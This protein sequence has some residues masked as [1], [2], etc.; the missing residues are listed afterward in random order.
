[1]AKFITQTGADSVP[2]TSGWARRAVLLAGLA[3]GATGGAAEL[4]TSVA[5][6]RPDQL[7]LLSAFNSACP[8][9]TGNLALRCRQLQ[10]LTAAQQKQAIVSLTPFQFLPQTGLPVKLWPKQ[11]LSRKRQ[12]ATDGATAQFVPGAVGGGSGDFSLRDGPWGLIAQAKFQTGQKSLPV[13]GF[14]SDSYELT[15]GADYSFSEQLTAGAAFAY[16]YGDTQ[17]DHDAGG[18]HSDIYR[19]MLFGNYF[20]PDGYYLNGLG[21]YTRYDNNLQR[22]FGYA[23]FSGNTA[24]TPGTDIYSAVFSFGKEFDYQEW[25]FN[26]YLRLEYL[27]LQVDGYLEQG[28][29]GL[30]YAV[31]GQ[32]DDSFILIPGLQISR[33]FS[34]PWGVLTPSLRFEYEHQ[35]LNDNRRIDM[36]LADAS[37]GSGRFFLN[38]GN[39]D[40]D[41]CDLGGSLA[42]TFA[43]GAAAFLRYEARLG[44]SNLGSQIV[45]LGMRL[46][47]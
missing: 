23:G 28:G 16:S 29:Q 35:F 24:S 17:M 45:E 41:Y 39:P 20:L 18:M 11:I 3:S 40:R 14:V 15:L 47:F 6:L 2:Q 32:A 8:G 9:A 1:M 38:T 19:A 33:A 44:Q 22:K 37:Y 30:A 27:H 43:G 36:R 10:G 12:D 4:P 46:P 42:A 25:S 21:I 31:A 7:S 34:L 13:G 26:P 5:G